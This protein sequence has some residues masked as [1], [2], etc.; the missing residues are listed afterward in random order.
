MWAPIHMRKIFV[1]GIDYT[2]T[3]ESLK[4]HFSAWGEVVDAV[5]MKDPATNR[6]RGFGFVTFMNPDHVDAVQRARPHKV[7]GRLVETKR[8]VPRSDANSTILPTTNHPDATHTRIFI[9]GLPQ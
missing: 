5:V 8:A 1:G 4:E 7:D 9:G 6:S 3:D 2:T